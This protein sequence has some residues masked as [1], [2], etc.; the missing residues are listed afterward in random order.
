MNVKLIALDLD[1]TTLNSENQLTE[2]TKQ[3]LILAARQGIEVVPV[4]G[5][6][7][8]SL[9]QE[10]LALDCIHYV[11]VSNGAE[12]RTVQDE[13][14]L[15][16]H[17]IA[18]SGAEEIKNALRKTDWM[19]EVYVKG[20]A[21]MEY[22][23]YEK[24]ERNQ[25]SYRDRDYVLATRVPVRGVLQLLDV[26]KSQIEK[27]AVYFESGSAAGRIKEELGRVRH[28]CVTSSGHNN[29]ELIA[30]N[31][32]KAKTLERLCMLLG[33]KLQE[34]MAAGDSQNDM[35]M[36]KAAGFAVAMGNGDENVK[37]C[38]DYIAATNDCDGLAEAILMVI[39]KGKEL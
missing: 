36:L 34:V 16:K 28:A 3:S 4:T 26:H 9:P 5:R 38:A 29:V 8:K 20:S 37:A 18:P 14:V 6:C 31:C 30:Q 25:I 12:I 22:A 2:R 27:V 33:I 21:Y 24:V 15:F 11:I 10:L 13:Q 17:Y 32:S 35:E 23:F 1:G 39:L 19:V 7:F